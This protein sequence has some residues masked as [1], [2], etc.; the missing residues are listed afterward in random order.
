MSTT[1]AG[2]P[3]NEGAA[4]G[5]ASLSVGPVTRAAAEAAPDLADAT[6]GDR[7]RLLAAVADALD[8]AVDELVPLADEETALGEARLRGEVSRTTGQL[9]MF[10][11]VVTEG[12]YLEVT[13]DHAR[14]D[15]TPPRPDLRRM[16]HPLGPVGVFAA[17]NFPFAFSVAGGDTASA[18]AAGC[19]VVVKAHPG[20]PRLSRLTARIVTAALTDVGAPTGTFGL[21]EGYETGRD[22][23]LDPH[24][25]AVGFTGSAAGGRALSD[26]AASRPD[27]I[28]FYGELGSI[29]PVVI[30]EAAAQR[31]GGQIAA[32]LVGSFTLGVGQFCT[33]P[34]VVF[35]PEGTGLEDAIRAATPATGGRMLT[36][37]ISTGFADG[38]RAL[39]ATGN[40][41]VVAGA[42]EQD[43]ADRATSPVVLATDVEA[44]LAQPDVLLDE[45]FGPTTLLVRYRDAAELAQG[46]HALPGSLTA[47]VH[48]ED[49][50][51]AE[52]GPIIAR[53][54]DTAGR[55]VFNG[56]PTG[57]AVTWSMQ[58]GGT[59][60]ATTSSLH[61]SVG[62][63][64]IRRF[65]RP[66]TYQDS[67]AALLPEALRDEN[68]WGL[69]R[70][71]NGRLT[72]PRDPADE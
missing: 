21:V 34:G 16:L 48:A 6:P 14:S 28:P 44:V 49:D 62:A 24:I 13:I 59:S 72:I 1:T 31:R 65:L 52:L 70:R 2:N 10:A 23:V 56:W 25:T 43:G 42:A 9:R 69:L 71:I 35:L 63:T 37:R 50:E 53:L 60:P 61:T 40:V 17:S 67:P 41:D 47:T 39:L 15:S 5:P 4:A 30:T 66:V 7:A 57:V 22:L 3:D 33:K 18:L 20:H 46:L 26:L 19:P 36:T 32:G 54:R 27:P 55:L 8:A 64:A 38:L 12:S 11:D 29:N 45:C 68:P 58:H 51:V